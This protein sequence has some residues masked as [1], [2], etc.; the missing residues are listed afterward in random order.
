MTNQTDQGFTVQVSGRA[1]PI[2]PRSPEAHGDDFA[3]LDRPF[4]LA[5][6]RGLEVFRG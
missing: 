1:S 3:S 4:K 2:H 5:D 6:T